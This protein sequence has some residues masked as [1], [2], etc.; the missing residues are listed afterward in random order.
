MNPLF[1]CSYKIQAANAITEHNK[2]KLD[3]IKER[4]PL[5]DDAKFNFNLLQLAAVSGNGKIFKSTLDY[6]GRSILKKELY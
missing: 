3:N 5:C 4:K 1:H 2:E 6:C